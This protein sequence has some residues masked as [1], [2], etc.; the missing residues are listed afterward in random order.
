VAPGRSTSI[1]GGPL[2]AAAAPAPRRAAA[3][4]P[5]L[6][7]GLTRATGVGVALGALALCLLASLAYGSAEMSWGTVLSAFTGFD[8]SN[9]HVI[10]REI[11]VPRTLIGLGVGTA[12]GLA[13]ALM[14]GVTRNPLAEP[15][16]LGVNAGAALA[17]VCAIFL[18]GVTSVSGY[19]WFAFLGAAVAAVAVYVLGSSGREGATPVKL[20][21]AGAVM[22][23][24]LTSVTSAVLVLD[25]DTLD[26]YRFWVVGS[27]AGRDLG[28]FLEVLPFLAVGSVVA[29][30]AGRA[31]NAL[32]L[33]DDVARCQRVALARAVAA[34]AIVLLAGAAVAA[35]GPI[36]FVGLAVPHAVR[37]IVGT[38]WR[39]V[40]PY[41]AIAGPI[42]L[43]ASDTL[44][45]VV[46]R[47]GELEVGIVTALIGAPVFIA[48][49][50]RRRLASL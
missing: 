21:L 48:L 34:V 9:A 8:G 32:E 4:G 13:G 41:S 25:V 16:I 7:R 36:A 45:R 47:P 10:V 43:L 22:A 11:R 20:A 30:A 18:L 44:G 14:Q 26:Q 1:A 49:V 33:G 39:W 23:A 2:P 17:V 6:S 31:L 5:L 28:V 12:L 29:L 3:R 38:D 50:R 42:L 40:L 27:L 24:L 37:M 46:V 35:A 19:V 15:G